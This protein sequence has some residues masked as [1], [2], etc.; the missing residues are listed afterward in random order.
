M[1]HRGFLL[2][3][4]RTL[5]R[6]PN[7]PWCAALLLALGCGGGSDPQGDSSGRMLLAEVSEREIRI[8]LPASDRPTDRWF[9]FGLRRFERPF[10]PAGKAANH[11]L[12]AWNLDRVFEVRESEGRM[13]RLR[14]GKPIVAA[15]SWECAIRE[16][17][18]RDFIG[19]YAH[20]DETL[21]T[22]SLWAD[23]QPVDLAAG[24]RLQA[25]KIVFR[26]RSVLHRCDTQ[27]PVAE[28]ERTYT[29]RDD[30]LVLSQDLFWL[31]PM[32]VTDGYLAMLPIRRNLDGATGELITDSG[33]RDFGPEEDLSAP[34]F[35]ARYTV[36]T[37]RVR[38]WGRQSGLRASVEILERSGLPSPEFHFS[39]APAYNKLYFDCTR[40]RS[41]K[42]G[43]RWR[44]RVRYRLASAP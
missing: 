15:G 12:D 31:E 8:F 3:L 10:D 6:G 24:G 34:G 44:V 33:R 17:G 28:Y 11:N 14:G 39:S 4:R 35:P 2:S 7:L 21:Q 23:D 41:V 20:G 36:G 42:A 40:N 13:E 22:F 27:T 25:R 43:E 18:A 16:K 26:H 5:R 30:G 37:R 9:E 29:F 32:E 19:S 38:I 1:V